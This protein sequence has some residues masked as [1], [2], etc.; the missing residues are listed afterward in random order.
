MHFN[1]GTVFNQLREVFSTLLS[2]R[3]VGWCYPSVDYYECSDH[4]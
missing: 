1:F 2:N 3:Q 4:V